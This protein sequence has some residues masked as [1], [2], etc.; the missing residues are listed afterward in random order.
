MHERKR[1][2]L[3]FLDVRL[4]IDTVPKSIVPVSK[5]KCDKSPNAPDGPRRRA[6]ELELSYITDTEFYSLVNRGDRSGFCNV[7]PYRATQGMELFLF[8]VR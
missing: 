4:A 8:A 6:F 7:N 1:G 5:P 3:G 2:L